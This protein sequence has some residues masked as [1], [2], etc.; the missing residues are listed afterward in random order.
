[1]PR[2]ITLS[3]VVQTACETIGFPPQ[4]RLELDC[5]PTIAALSTA[6]HEFRKEVN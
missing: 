1:M 2:P 5:L 4:L 6:R 3:Q